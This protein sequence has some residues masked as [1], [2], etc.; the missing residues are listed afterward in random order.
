[1][2]TFFKALF[3]NPRATGAVFPSS[4]Y[5]AH[6]MAA[7]IDT[8]KPGYILELGPGTGAITKG[9][10]ESG[11]PAEKLIALELV[12]DFAEKLQ[13]RFPGVTVIR[14]NAMNLSELLKDKLPVHTIISSLPLRSLSKN[15]R[16]IILAEI[17][18]VLGP[19]GQFIQ[20]TYSMKNDADFYPKNF[21]LM[22]SFLV[23]RN[24]PPARVTVFRVED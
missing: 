21:K 4:K 5:L 19:G 12:P 9:I 6:R 2:R 15:D 14:G 17:P 10:L 22:D 23:W 3:R 13:R 1:M 16:R 24:I 11:I 8:T 20:F 7:C 18:K